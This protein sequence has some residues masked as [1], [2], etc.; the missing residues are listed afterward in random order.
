MR[1][2]IRWSALALALLL[3]IGLAPRGAG[4]AN[5]PYLIGVVVS[6]SGP[7]AS[8]GRPEADSV[9]LAVDAINKA[10]GVN[11]RQLQVT[12]LD[13]ESYPTAAVNDVRK[14]LDQ[15]V[16]AI[17][18]SSITQATMAVV[19][20]VTQAHIPLISLASNAQVIQP[21]ADRHWIFKMPIND[22]HVAQTLQEFMKK[23]GLTQV[24]VVY[25]DDDYGKTGLSHFLD[26]G[27]KLGFTVVDSEAIAASATDATTQLTK[28]K[29]A[30]PQAIVVWSTLPSVGVVIKSYHELGLSYPI[31]FSDGAANGVFPK[32]A[33]AALNGAYIASTKIN[34]ADQLPASDPQRTVLDTY[35]RSFASEYPKDLPVSIFGGFG[36]D[37]VHVLAVALASAKSSDPEKLRS[38][39][40][41]A[42][43]DGVTGSYRLSSG[44]HNGLSTFSTVITQIE[45]NRFTL[46]K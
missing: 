19:P 43:W 33:G 46:A 12:I 14:L 6:E 31:Y 15:H 10:G 29:A 27:K 21:V 44:D 2:A 45:N 8:L 4:A 18:G 3:G 28:I 7:A 9:Q 34:I 5:E 39:I 36:Y 17:I 23:K 37:A 24:A 20:I 38:A 42:S 30:N 16:I 1:L 26:A 13:D 25:R 41:H 11:G 22:F 32:Q 40:E 35:I